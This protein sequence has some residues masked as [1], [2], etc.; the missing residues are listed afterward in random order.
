MFNGGYVNRIL[1]VDLTREKVDYDGLNEE[2]TL[3]YIGGQ[4]PPLGSSTI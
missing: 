2:Y 4:D 1:K 3:K